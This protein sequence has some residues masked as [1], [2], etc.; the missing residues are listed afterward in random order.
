MARRFL[1]VILVLLLGWSAAH[2]EGT[3]TGTWPRVKTAADGTQVTLYQPQVDKWDM[4]V[5]LHFRLAAEVREPGAAQAAP[6]ALEMTAQTNTDLSTRTVVVYNIKL[7]KASFPSA[8][9]A[10]AKRLTALLTQMLPAEPIKMPLD[11]ILAYV[12]PAA[13]PAPA[14]PAGTPAPAATPAGK[15]AAA[16]APAGKPAAAVSAPPARTITAPPNPPVILHSETPAVLV[17]FDGEPAF[18][19]IQGTV[20]LFAINTNWDVFQEEGKPATYLLNGDAWLQAPKPTGPWAPVDKLPKSF[21]SLPKEDNWAEVHKNLPGKAISR[22]KMPRVLVSVKPAELILLDGK[23]NI[24]EISKTQLLWVTNTKSDLFQCKT[25]KKYYYL[26]SGRWFRA[27]GLDGPWTFCS[28]DLPADFAKIPKDHPKAS[29]RASVPGTPEAQEAVMLAQIPHKAEVKRSDLTVEIKYSGE[30]QFKPIENTGVAYA[31]NTPNDV[32]RVDNKYYCCYQAVWFMAPSPTGPW[33]VA[34]TIPASIYTIPPSCPKYNVTYVTIYESTPTTVTTGYT[35][36][37]MGAFI[38]GACVVYGSGY[39]YPPY[40]YYPPGV[41][42]PVYYPCPYTYGMAAAYNPYTGTYARGAACYGPYGG[43]GYGAA[44]NPYTG[45]YARGA[46]AYGP[47]GGAGYAEAYNPYTGAYGQKAAAYGPGG[48][49]AYAARG[50]NPSTGTGAAT[51]QRSNP[52]A[53]WGQSAVTQGDDWAHTAHYSDSRGTAA[54]FET[55]TGAKGAGVSTQ[56]GSTAVAKDAENNMYAAHDGNVYKTDGDSWQTYEDGSWQTVED[57]KTQAQTQAQS[58]KSQAQTNAQSQ[59][60]QAQ[61]N[62]QTRSTE[63][64]AN[65]QSRSS[66]AQANAQGQSAQTQA[67]AQ[68]RST[69]AQANAQSRSSQAQAKAG[70]ASASGASSQSKAAWSQSSSQLQQDRAARADSAQRQSSY[71][72]WKSG[73]GQSSRSSSSG[74]RSGGRR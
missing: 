72:S 41:H 15:Q 65:A 50:Y 12:V 60:A 24:K 51:Y 52:Y 57:P 30:P 34:D 56:Y 9:E 42:Y 68:A 71:N 33:A 23:P 59:S 28:A 61:A 44:Y 10:T 2:A 8:D 48:Q 3:T 54:A 73:S 40:Y 11:Q 55:S 46:A 16:P 67:N 18:A 21:W 39:Y 63:A 1:E 66:Q 38:L 29:V 45:T 64:Q 43:C 25:D 37:Y 26:V 36:G 22:D 62:A 14:K 35:S 32:F 7:L 5:Q 58:T 49:A 27:A 20:L 19:P 17:L 6:A 13:P 53:S 47:Y 4:Y 69:E 31:V 70:T 74:S